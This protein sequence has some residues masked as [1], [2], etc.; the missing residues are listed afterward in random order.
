MTIHEIGE[1]DGHYFIAT[2]FIEG[3]TLRRR[4]AESRIEIGA[5]LDIAIQVG[6]ALAAAHAKGI[7]H[8]DIKPENVMLRT[9]GY[10]KVLDFGLAKLTEKS[11]ANLEAST[12]ANTQPGMVFGTLHYMSPE[13]ARGQPVDAQTD[14]WSLGVV[15]YEIVSR[16]APH[17]GESASDV[18]VSILERDPPPLT[19][20]APEAPAE[21]AR[22]VQ[23]CLQKDRKQRYQSAEDVLSDLKRLKRDIDSRATAP[24]MIVD[25]RPPITFL[26]RRRATA[27]IVLMVVLVGVVL[28]YTLLYR[29][30][31]APGVAE[32]R[33]LTVLPLKNLSGDSAQDYFADGMTDALITDLAKIWSGRMSASRFAALRDAPGPTAL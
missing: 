13:Q 23:K 32:I 11:S 2:E 9:D 33:S 28:A 15:L 12:W 4:L 5:A 3:Q 7:V 30:S 8:R 22:I 26:T 19:R 1:A 14:I 18:L 20:Y 25:S 31:N 27:A 17:L 29:P 24:T 10:V 16:Q 21:L 6:S